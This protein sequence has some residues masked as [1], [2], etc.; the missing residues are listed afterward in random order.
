MVVVVGF[1]MNGA[2]LYGY[3]KCRVGAKKNLSSVASSFL[4]MQLFKTVSSNTEK[5]MYNYF[6]LI[7][8]RS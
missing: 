5:N 4:S 7:F 1:L 6:C 2:N 3:V 8:P